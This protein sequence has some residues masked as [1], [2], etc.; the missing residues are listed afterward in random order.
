[1]ATSETHERQESGGMGTNARSRAKRAVTG[2]GRD[3]SLA[4]LAGAGLLVRAL[5]GGGRR[6]L[7]ALG[8][9]ALIGVGVWQRRSGGPTESTDAT[10]AGGTETSTQDRVDEGRGDETA[11]GANPRG[12]VGDPEVASN[13]DEGDVQFVDGRD[14]GERSSPSPD[15]SSPRRDAE[16]RPKPDLDESAPEDPRRN[17]GDPKTVDLSEASLADEASEATGPSPEQA[18]PAL[19]GTDPEPMSEKAPQR[20]GEATGENQD[21]ADTEADDE[22]SS[23][24]DE[25]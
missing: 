25:E 15:S 24:D 22:Q 19:E 16:P 18:Y 1:M 9:L 2:Y 3:G 8:G 10:A 20:Y 21:A 6:A 4:M 13:P 14:A 12:T 17:D 5:G 7:Q 11:A 23:A